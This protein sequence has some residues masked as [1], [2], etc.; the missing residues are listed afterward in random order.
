MNK[1]WR[2]LPALLHLLVMLAYSAH[3]QVPNETTREVS[4]TSERTP[5][6][7]AELRVVD[8][9]TGRGVPL[10]ELETVN[11]LRLVTD[12][13]GRIALCEPGWIDREVFFHIHGHGYSVP[14]DGFGF[15]GVRVRPRAGE[16]NV[17]KVRRRNIAQRLCRLTGEGLYRDTVLL[18]YDAPLADPLNP[19]QVAGQDSVLAV[20]HNNQIHWFWGDT[21]R[22]SYPLGLF[23]VAGAVTPLEPLSD[24]AFDVADGIELRYFTNG[25]GFARAMMPLDERPEGVVWITSLLVLPDT[26]GQERML[27]HYTRRQGLK[28][29]YEHGFAVFDDARS[30]FNSLR[31]LPLEETWRHPRGHPITYEEGGRTY[32]LFGSPHPNVRVPADWNSVLD[33]QQY[34]ALTCTRSDGSQDKPQLDAAGRPVW[35]WQKELPPVDSKTEQQWIEAGLLDAAQARFVPENADSPGERIVLHSGTVRWNGF[36][37]RWV[38]IAGQI[39]GKSSFLGE[40]WYAEARHPTGPFQRAALI[41]SHDRQS[42]YNVCHHAFL[43]R[44]EGRVIHFEGTYTHT[45]SGNPYRTPRYEY[46]QVL[47]RLE[48]DT[49]ALR[50]AQAD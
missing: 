49:Q 44:D 22:M 28:N 43:D 30:Q 27:A 41:T 48:L 13:A 39:G 20:V 18:G 25:S 35:R 47:Y 36:R 4:P 9:E 15:Q 7:W 24:P 45:F 17:I 46:N 29:E 6:G 8:E 31:Q 23:R 21:H 3:A 33:P 16:I 5:A 38:L 37:Q 11:A 34:E 40:V 10:V 42:F 2:T 1:P 32:L 50:A 12:N 26:E 14:A 19:G